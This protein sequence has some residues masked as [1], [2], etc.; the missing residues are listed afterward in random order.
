MPQGGYDSLASVSWH[1]LAIL[2]TIRPDS[3]NQNWCMGISAHEINV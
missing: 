2:C 1:R 3:Q